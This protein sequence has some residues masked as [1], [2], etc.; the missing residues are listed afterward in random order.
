MA[1]M[2]DIRYK[3]SKNINQYIAELK[4]GGKAR[5]FPR[6]RLSDSEWRKLQ[7]ELSKEDVGLVEYYSEKDKA[8]Y[9][10]LNLIAENNAPSPIRRPV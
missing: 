10:G 2:N 7:N 8:P 9:M 1:D 3:A 5:S 6:K 4:A